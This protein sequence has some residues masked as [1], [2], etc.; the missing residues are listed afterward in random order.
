M[1]SVKN[2]ITNLSVESDS[3]LV[4]LLF[5]MAKTEFGMNRLR[6]AVINVCNGGFGTERERGV[7]FLE[8]FLR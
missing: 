7:Q 4:K 3:S 8:K 1:L 2:W 6:H 5:E